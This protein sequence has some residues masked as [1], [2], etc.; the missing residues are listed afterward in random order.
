MTVT[1]L[2]NYSHTLHFIPAKINTDSTTSEFK[3]ALID[4]TP[5][6]EYITVYLRGK[7]LKGKPV[8]LNHLQPCIIQSEESGVADDN[9]TTVVNNNDILKLKN[10]SNYEREGNEERL[11]NEHNRFIEFMDITNLIHTD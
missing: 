8:E 7:Q 1:E 6:G 3:D 10:I 4:E 2:P 5:G 9:D 11:V